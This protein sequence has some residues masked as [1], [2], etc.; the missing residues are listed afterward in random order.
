[1]LLCLISIPPSNIIF[2][3]F[4]LIL[5]V[6]FNKESFIFFFL[7]GIIYF[8]TYLLIKRFKMSTKTYACSS[9]IYLSSKMTLDDLE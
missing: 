6:L 1:M 5:M 8:F 4:N 7:N 3:S 2:I 9:V